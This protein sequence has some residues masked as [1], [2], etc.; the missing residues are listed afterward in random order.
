MAGRGAATALRASEEEALGRAFD[1]RLVRRLG[2]YLRPYRFAV[3]VALALLLLVSLSDLAG[4]YLIKVA[5]DEHITP[6]RL[7][8]LGLLALLYVGALAG[9][10]AFRYGQNLV[11]QYV[12]QR[13]MADL[14]LEIFSH[15][16]RMP[17]SYFDRTPVGRLVTR[18][19]N[20]VDALNELLTSGAVAIFGDIFTLAAIVAAL[21]ALDWRL[22]MVT[23]LALIPLYPLVRWFRGKM[24]QSYRETRVALARINAFLNERISGMQIVQLFTAEKLSAASF[25]E[26]NRDYLAAN[27]R[28]TFY[29]AMLY[30]IVGVFA[31][32]SIALIVWYGGRQV[33]ALSF[34]LGALV[35]FIRYVER[36]FQPIRDLSEKYNIMQS[37]MASS[38]RI[39]ELLDSPEEELRGAPL[40]GGHLRGSIEFRDVWFAYQ[41]EDWVLKD[42]SFT[43]EPGERV[44]FVGATGAGKTS[45]ISLLSR[46]Y[47]PQ[48]GQIL[49]DGID[50]RNLDTAHLRRSVGV[51][52]QDPFLFTG[53]IERNIRLR[54][55]GIEAADLRAAARHVNAEV[56]IERLP[57]GYQTKVGERGA[58]LSVGQKQL[59]AF[60]RAIAFNPSVLLVLDEATSSIDSETEALIQEALRRLM[61]ERTTLVIAHRLSTVQDVD[62]IIVLHHGEIVEEGS[63]QELL[64]RRGRYF[65]LYELQYLDREPARA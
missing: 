10:F 2:R 32:V 28:S 14:R 43:V 65:R 30:P 38:E 23:F 3:A 56:F 57:D 6:R 52:L 22:A 11:T 26:K 37:A 47:L 40:P 61:S 48:R 64:A 60:A 46:F 44:A 18:L 62:R 16:Q 45:I 58:G 55:E 1:A 39:F 59:V 12:G 13:A 25:E 21:L 41:G 15:I 4:P 17:L 63:H 29:S 42:I 8:G 5:I 49:V 20:D 24:R 27:I 34:T 33:A 7:D 19:T 51:V 35:A 54:E 31:A 53:T 50:I 36:F 9:S